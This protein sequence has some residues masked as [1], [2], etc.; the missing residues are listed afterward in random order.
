VA[1]TFELPPFLGGKVESAVY[2]RWLQRK[3]RA[4]VTR[5]RKRWN[6]QLSIS[7][8]KQS[9]HSAVL[10]SRG[11]DFYTNER[12]DWS[13]LSKYDNAKSHAGGSSYK[14]KFALLPTVDHVGA[15][16]RIPNFEICGWRT[17]DCKND[18]SLAELRAFCRKVLACAKG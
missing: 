5:D 4:Q 14:S 15:N 11:R 6:R 1:V 13:L 12:L 9:I 2:L 8:Y 18:L 7:E 3:A 17:N 16:S 10:R